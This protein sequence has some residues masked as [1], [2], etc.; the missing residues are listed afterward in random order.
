MKTFNIFRWFR[1]QQQP[2]PPEWLMQP[3]RVAPRERPA[4]VFK[5]AQRVSQ[6]DDLPY[7]P[8]TDTAPRIFEATHVHVATGKP[9]MLTTW[10]E[11]LE[12]TG[13]DAYPLAEYEDADGGTY[14]QRA[15]RFSDGRF[16]E[17]PL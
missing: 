10:G 12:V 15:S 2:K 3:K 5:A 6:P 1:K 11:R 13:D 14:A 7:Y 16:L 17:L 8:E 9:Y 4:L